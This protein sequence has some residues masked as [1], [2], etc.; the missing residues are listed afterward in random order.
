MCPVCAAS[1]TE[2][3]YSELRKTGPLSFLSV[4]VTT[5]TATAMLLLI[6]ELFVGATT[7][8]WKGKE[9]DILN[10]LNITWQPITCS[11]IHTST[12]KENVSEISLS[13]EPCT[14]A[15]PVPAST[16]NSPLVMTSVEQ[17]I[18]CESVNTIH[19]NTYRIAGNFR[20]SKFSPVSPP[21]EIFAVLIFAFSAGY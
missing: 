15:V 4:T 20:G 11:Y 13:T 18:D 1:D 17:K 21:E 6:T 7:K 2:A 3:V 19:H 5:T 8:A 12:S 14:V 16:E 9:R 10:N